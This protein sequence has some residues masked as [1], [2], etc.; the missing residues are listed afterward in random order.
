LLVSCILGL[1]GTFTGY[2]LATVSES[3]LH[4]AVGHASAKTR[5]RWA[6]GSW[7]GRQLIEAHFGHAVVHHG[8]TFRENH[9][10]QFDSESERRI[11]DEQL[12]A[13][14]QE[15][16]IRLRYGLITDGWGALQFVAIPGIACVLISMM[17]SGQSRVWFLLP[18]ILPICSTP[19]LSICIHPYL[20]LPRN[21]A[22]DAP[23]LIRWLLLSPYG[24]WARKHHYVHHHTPRYNFNL[25][26]GGD[27]LW[28]THRRPTNQE[29]QE[30]IGIGLLK[31][32]HFSA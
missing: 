12:I 5:R 11:L 14:E 3:S 9:V 31:D 13:N 28:R 4:R 23:K 25:L 30:M 29:I 8:K 2:L 10:T 17:V 26:P 16:F 24:D 18:A 1:I 15:V 6:K 32:D 27:I 22:E 20:H 19:L 7:F 21:R